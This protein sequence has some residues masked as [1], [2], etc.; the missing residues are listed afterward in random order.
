MNSIKLSTHFNHRLQFYYNN[1][2]ASGQHKK[3]KSD[4]DRSQR[5]KQ[6]TTN[7]TAAP[8]LT[9]KFKKIIGSDKIFGKVS[10]FLPRLET[11]SSYTFT[12]TMDKTESMLSLT[13]K[14]NKK[15][16]ALRDFAVKKSIVGGQEV[17]YQPNSVTRKSPLAVSDF[18]RDN[19]E[20]KE[21]L[22]QAEKE[23]EEVNV[24]MAKHA[25]NL[26]K[27]G[28]STLLD[29]RLKVAFDALFELAICLVTLYE[30]NTDD[31]SILTVQELAYLSAV[32]ILDIGLPQP[33]NLPEGEEFLHQPVISDSD[34]RYL[35]NGLSRDLFR[36]KFIAHANQH[37]MSKDTRN[38]S[39][40]DLMGRCEE[41]S[42]NEYSFKRIDEPM[43]D[44]IANQLVVVFPAITIDVWR[45]LDRIKKQEERQSTLE[46]M[47][48][49]MKVDDANAELAQAMDVDDGDNVKILD[50]ARKEGRDAARKEFNRLKQQETRRQRKK[51]SAGGQVHTPSAENGQSSSANSNSRNSKSRKKHLEKQP[52]KPSKSILKKSSRVHWSDTEDEESVD[53]NSTNHS[54]ASSRGGRRRRNKRGGRGGDQKGQGKG[55]SNRRNRN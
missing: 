5:K 55:R 39:V 21:I 13:D 36:I 45:H 28:L 23:Q 48:E 51:S 42:D 33:T 9:D 49:K 43:I 17:S 30:R 8:T 18:L 38:I 40:G 31:E 44:S 46:T 41:G 22:A 19:Q 50:E 32:K 12:T 6:S 11:L 29:E 20:V 37:K 54:R 53:S 10:N 1:M 7:G 26:A 2:P 24:K 15:A 14:I 16:D 52:S 3:R 25:H 4:G 27:I 35:H 47:M 34:I